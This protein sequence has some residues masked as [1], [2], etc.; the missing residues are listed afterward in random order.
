MSCAVMKAQW[1]SKPL[2][3]ACETCITGMML[4]TADSSPIHASDTHADCRE[5]SRPALP[6]RIV[7]T[8][9]TCIG[10]GC[11]TSLRQTI[12]KTMSC[13]VCVC[14]CVLNFL[15]PQRQILTDA[16]MHCQI[17]VWNLITQ[18]HHLDGPRLRDTPLEIQHSASYH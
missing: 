15:E 12:Q 5:L 6:E 8:F 13:R 1:L 3:Q 18:R 11:K 17:A 16:T 4:H 7:G 9:T 2:L 14:V 10:M